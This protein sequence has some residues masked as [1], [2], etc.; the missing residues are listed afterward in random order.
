MEVKNESAA[1]EKPAVVV[2]PNPIEKR[3]ARSIYAQ[4]LSTTSTTSAGADGKNSVVSSA[5]TSVV[6]DL[7]VKGQ[8]VDWTEDV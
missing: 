5:P 2:N 3:V 1:V 7:S 4:A 8:K 6:D